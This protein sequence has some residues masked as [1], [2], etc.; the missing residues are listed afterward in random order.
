M[1]GISVNWSRIMTALHPK[2]KVVVIGGGISG[3]SAAFS[4]FCKDYDVRVLE[5]S[6]NPGGLIKSERTTDGFLLEHAATC[7]FNFLPEVDFFCQSLGLSKHQVFRRET[8]KKRYL[9]KNGRAVPVPNSSLG[10]VSTDLISLKGKIRL[11]LEPFMPRGGA[12]ET[13]A[14]FASRRFG[15]EVFEQTLE[16]Y[17]SGTLAGNA[18]HTCLRSTFTQFA[19][20]EDE[21]GSILKGTVV[22]KLKGVRTSSCEAR[23]FSFNDGMAV[24]TDVIA[25]TL[26]DAFESDCEVTGVE[27]RGRQWSVTFN[28]QGREEV[29]QADAVL[30]ATPT[31][32][33]AS[34][35][36]PL[37]NNLGVTLSGIQYSPMAI[38]YLG[39]D[40]Q[41]ISHPL[42]GIGCLV[43]RKEKGVDILG[44]LWPSTL[45]SG[46]A[47]EGAALF[48]NYMGGARHPHKTLKS[49]E[50][51]ATE[52]INDIGK[53]VGIKGAPT[54][55]KVIRHPNALPQYN[56]GHQIFLK[57]VAESLK[58]LPGLFLSGNYLNGVSVRACISNGMETAA[59]IDQLLLASGRDFSSSAT[60]NQ[61]LF[62]L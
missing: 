50:E 59:N 14:Q 32:A 53:L 60:Q 57:S 28:R 6:S 13:V 51:L 55:S 37:N 22:R 15:K 46:R 5:K 33:A 21:Y 39:F 12:D 34:L 19:A 7:V 10:F 18:D 44:S 52:S 38:S 49:D 4:L 1:G 56:I 58:S 47:P 31:K 43:P 48:M 26:G 17:I 16:P 25:A 62:K 41:D 35:L 36:S 11:L 8:A 20:L 9:V 29:C 3:L 2:K 40:R 54:F 30:I 45:F 27:R 23:V 42:D 24:L 61:K